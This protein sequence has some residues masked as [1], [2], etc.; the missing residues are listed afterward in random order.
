MKRVQDMRTILYPDAIHTNIKIEVENFHKDIVQEVAKTV[1]ENRVVVVRMKYNYAVYV[2]RKALKKVSIKLTYVEYGNYIF[3][4]RTR[5][6]L[7]MWTG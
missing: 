1:M 2:V 3:Q 5:V 6:T 7:K 4:W